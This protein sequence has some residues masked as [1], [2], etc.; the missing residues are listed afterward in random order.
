MERDL[1][2]EH[3]LV[4]IYYYLDIILIFSKI[5]Y[6]LYLIVFYENHHSIL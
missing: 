4:L 2:F 6:S 3:K 5:Y 1:T